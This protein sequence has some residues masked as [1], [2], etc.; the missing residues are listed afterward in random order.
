MDGNIDKK[1]IESEIETIKQKVT[2]VKT[3]SVKD[4]T[5]NAYSTAKTKAKEYSKSV[6]DWFKNMTGK[7]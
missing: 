3:D 5:K 6:T 2:N 7:G 1:K 4:K